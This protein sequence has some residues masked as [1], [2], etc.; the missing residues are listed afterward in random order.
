MASEVIVADA[1]PPFKPMTETPATRVFAVAVLSAIELT[2]ML[3]ALLTL[4][5]TSVVVCPDRVANPS[6]TAIWMPPA[7]PPGTSASAELLDVAWILT[8]PGAVNVMAAV[9]VRPASVDRLFLTTAT[10]TPTAT[11]P[12][13][14]L[15]VLIVELWVASEVTLRPPA[16]TDP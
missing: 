10:V 1:K 12:V 13:V 14:T 5:S 3:L 8:G 7:P 2:R 4:P 15:S 11:T 9:P 16:P 6:S